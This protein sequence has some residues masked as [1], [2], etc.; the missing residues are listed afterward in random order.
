MGQQRW[1]RTLN[2]EHHQILAGT[3]GSMAPGFETADAL[4]ASK[5]ADDYWAKNNVKPTTKQAAE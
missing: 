5:Q 3:D 2:I 4:Q 1:L